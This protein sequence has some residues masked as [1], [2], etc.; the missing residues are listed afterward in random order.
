MLRNTNLEQS[1]LAEFIKNKV[2]ANDSN[3][4]DRIISIREY[5]E[6]RN[7][8][9]NGAFCDYFELGNWFY[10]AMQACDFDAG[11]FL[12]EVEQELEIEYREA[13]KERAEREENYL[14][15]VGAK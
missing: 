9:K 13:S 7:E 8:D 4:F 14:R 1:E 3:L 15:M 2:L 12:D 11:D 5:I 10:E 6:A